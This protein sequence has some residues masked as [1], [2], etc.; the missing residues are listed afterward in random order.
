LHFVRARVTLLSRS[1]DK[2]GQPATWRT[3][4]TKGRNQHVVPRNGGWAVK[5]EGGQQAS[6][7]HGTQREAIDR[8][9]E[10]SRNQ[11]SELFVH[12]RD[13]RIRERDSHGHEPNP[14]MGLSLACPHGAGPPQT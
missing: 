10:V 7:I 8:G 13:G 1:A 14:P 2:R 4:M 9:R 12:G 5:P 6:S 3:E 11:H